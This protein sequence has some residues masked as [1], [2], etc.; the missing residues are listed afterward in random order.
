MGGVERGLM[1]WVA[2]GE[3]ERGKRR[4]DEWCQEGGLTGCVD[5]IC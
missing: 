5:G 1:E 4:V 2:E 3:N